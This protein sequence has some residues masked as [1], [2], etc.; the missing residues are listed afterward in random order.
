MVTDTAFYR[1]RY[2]HSAEDTPDKLSYSG[3]ARAT[4]GLYRT[5]AAV[6]RD[7]LGE[8]AGKAPPRPRSHGSGN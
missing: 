4:E 2:Y 3:L 5:F 7:G 8:V 1:Y 6:A